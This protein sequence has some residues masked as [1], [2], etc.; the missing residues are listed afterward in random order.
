MSAASTPP[1]RFSRYYSNDTRPTT[2]RHSLFWPVLIFLF[3]AGS[4]SFYQVVIMEDHWDQLTQTIDNMD[5]QVKRGQYEKAKFFA[6]ARDA[7]LL[8]PKDANANEVAVYF[9]LKEL[10]QAQPELMALT[11]ATD[12]PVANA[13]PKETLAQTNAAP[14]QPSPA[15]NTAPVPASVPAAKP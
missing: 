2:P 14:V 5:T 7:L 13:T 4:L 1:P 9:K 6:I 12:L 11:T 15:T 10:Q 3:G 8:A